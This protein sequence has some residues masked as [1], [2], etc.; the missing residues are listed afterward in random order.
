M[1]ITFAKAP[2][3]ELIA[4][5]RWTPQGSSA[6]EPGIVQ[7]GT[8][9]TVFLGGTKQ[10]EFYMRLGAVLYKVGFDRSERLI[11]PGLPFILHQPVYRFRS[12]AESRTSVLYQVGYGVFSVHAVPPYRSW[13]EFLPFVQG[14]IEALLQSRPEADM[15]QPFGQTS[16]RYID[17]FGEHF[18]KGKDIHSFLSGVFGISVSLPEAIAKPA[19]SKELKSLFTKV[20]VPIKIGELTVSVGDGQFNSQLGIL[21]DTTVTSAGIEPSMNAIMEV[22]SAAY[23]VAHELF[24]EM[25][26]PIRAL[27]QPEGADVK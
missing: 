23:G 5:L 16:L 18:T 3:I 7:A 13:S 26:Q 19:V 25:T 15:K 4:E 6:L 17:F 10:E 8:A 21:L 2:L 24:L 11:P 1:A 12:E 14:G 27:M 20:V 22:F 9:P